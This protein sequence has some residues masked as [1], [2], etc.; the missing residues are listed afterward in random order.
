MA[1]LVL[2]WLTGIVLLD[3]IIAI[4]VASVIMKAAY[5]LTVKSYN[6]LIDY[7]LFDDEQNRIVNIICEHQADYIHYHVLITRRAGPEIL[8]IFTWLCIKT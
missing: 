5:D 7:W 3:A 8:L 6:A 1:G 4:G 2:I